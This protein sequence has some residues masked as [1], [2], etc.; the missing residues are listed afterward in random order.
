[1]PYLDPPQLTLLMPKIIAPDQQ[2]RLQCRGVV[3]CKFDA[4]R[5]NY[6]WGD[7]SHFVPSVPEN[8]KHAMLDSIEYH[9][10]PL[11]K[12]LGPLLVIHPGVGLRKASCTGFKCSTQQCSV[13]V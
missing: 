11:S 7:F 6:V 5:A 13:A 12:S 10:E 3:Q 2:A 4:I 8:G 1:M 9:G